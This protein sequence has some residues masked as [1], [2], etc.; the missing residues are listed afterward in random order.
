MHSYMHHMG[1]FNTET[2][3]LSRLERDIYRD[4]RDMYYA[5][6]C[7]LDGSDMGKLAKRLRCR[8]DEEVAA[9]QF[10]LEEFFEQQDAGQFFHYKI[11]ADLAAM[12]ALQVDRGTV[13][14]NENERQRR[15]RTRRSAMFSAL[16]AKGVFM[17]GL[18]T[19]AALYQ[20]CRDH[21]IPI[22]SGDPVTRDSVTGHGDGT[23]NQTHNPIPINPPNPPSGGASAGCDTSRQKAEGAA[24]QS[25]KGTDPMAVATALCAYFPPHR[26][27]RL[28]HV[29]GKVGE[30]MAAGSVTSAE[31]LAAASSQ[32]DRL[33]LEG[34]R[35]CPSVIRWLRDSRWLDT[36]ATAADGDTVPA[37]WRATR[38]GVE[39]MGKRV[40]LPPYDDSGFRL[41]ADYEAEVERRLAA[42]GVPA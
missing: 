7:A 27:T 16:S 19:M 33:G 40:G 30:L 35:S 21:G 15:S 11:E 3:H 17:E 23:G 1:D 4:M 24:V 34:G 14:K 36:V 32:A 37:N 20:A 39:A 42:Q 28:A 41:F 10:V 29:A 6:E 22:P 2:L 38:S 26:R 13:K 12:K 31:L 8:T 18:T 9:M 25:G 5:N